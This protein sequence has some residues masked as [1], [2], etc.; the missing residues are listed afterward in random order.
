[1]LR[2]NKAH[3]RQITATLSR[4]YADKLERVARARGLTLHA[5]ATKVMT[6]L[7]QKA[8]VS[9]EPLP[10]K[11]KEPS[12][13]DLTETVVVEIRLPLAIRLQSAARQMR[14]KLGK[15]LT[16]TELARELLI[17]E[18]QHPTN[19]VQ[20]MN[21]QVDPEY[22]DTVPFSGKTVPRSG[23]DWYILRL[24]CALDTRNAIFG[25]AQEREES[26]ATMVRN[27]LNDHLPE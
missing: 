6:A 21:E 1:M 25:A 4:N 27:I 24:R 18:C 12:P 16:M 20:Q 14:D 22:V 5:F 15:P 13:D 9:D 17:H 3:T 23:F 7:A 11:N 26:V 8:Q 10:A 19:I 2:M